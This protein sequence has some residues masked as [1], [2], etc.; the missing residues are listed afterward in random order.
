MFF[1]VCPLTYLLN[2]IVLLIQM[3]NTWT[4]SLYQTVLELCASTPLEGERH[5]AAKKNLKYVC[6]TRFKMPSFAMASNS[7]VCQDL[8]GKIDIRSIPAYSV[9][10]LRVPF[11]LFLDRQLHF[12]PNGIYS[13]ARA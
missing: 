2:E 13:W 3:Q 7:V 10:F 5:L 11:I 4:A 1:P 9:H 6:L 12:P 8:N